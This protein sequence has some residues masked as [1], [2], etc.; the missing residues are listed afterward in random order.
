MILDNEADLVTASVVARTTSDT[1]QTCTAR[2][3]IRAMVR[4]TYVT[5]WEPGTWFVG[6]SHIIRWPSSRQKSGVWPTSWPASSRRTQRLTDALIYCDMAIG[7][8]GRH[9]PV[10][11]RLAEIHARYGPITW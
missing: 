10:E 1:D 3:F 4:A 9:M 11:Q 2:A 8:D 6:W 7:P 5:G